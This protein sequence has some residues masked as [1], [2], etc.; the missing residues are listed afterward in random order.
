M[1]EFSKNLIDAIKEIDSLELVNHN[2]NSG[3]VNIRCKTSKHPRRFNVIGDLNTKTGNMRL[4]SE[5]KWISINKLGFKSVE[6]IISWVKK[7]IELLS[8]M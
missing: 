7:D 8:R 1:N 3:F 6:S 4:Y 2:N 5:G